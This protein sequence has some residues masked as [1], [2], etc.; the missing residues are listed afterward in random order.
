M[1]R[2][3]SV[4]FFTLVDF[5]L[6]ALFFG[7]VL[8]AVG[9]AQARE[10]AEEQRTSKAAVDSIRKATGISDLTELTDRLTRLG[11]LSKAQEARQIV[12]Q[13]GGPEAARRSLST[14][15]AAGGSDSV[16]ARLERLQQRE[17]AGKPHCLYQETARGKEAIVLATVVGTDSTLAFERETPHLQAVLTRMGRTFDDVRLLRLEEF[18]RI[19]AQL[20]RLEPSCLYTIDFIERTRF[21]D[22]RDAARGLF[23]MRIRRG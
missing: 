3:D 12:A 22:A 18:R 11:P 4:F 5:L 14:V 23:Y 1:K 21:V 8:L 6:T 15:S 10:D 20:V 13:A 16:A 9:R 19:F 7:F 2:D 17:G